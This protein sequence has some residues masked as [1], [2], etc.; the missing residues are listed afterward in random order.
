MVTK[1]NSG[2]VVLIP[3]TILSARERDGQISYE[4]DAKSWDIPENVIIKNEN[5]EVQRAMESFS[6]QIAQ[7]WQ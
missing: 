1:Y 7:R 3:A 5:A 6:K 4:V 2:D